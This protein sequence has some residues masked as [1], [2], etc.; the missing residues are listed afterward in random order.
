MHITGA[1][2]CRCRH[3]YID[4][5]N[6]EL[7]TETVKKLFL[8]YKQLLKHPAHRNRLCT[9]YVYITGGEPF[10]HKDFG[11][12][13]SVMEEFSPYFQFVMLSNG[14][15][16]EDNLLQR[17]RRLPLAGFQVSIDGERTTHDSIRGAGNFDQVIAGIQTLHGHGI[18]VTVSFTANSLNYRQ[19]PQVADICRTYHAATLWSDRYV[20]FFKNKVISSLDQNETREYIAM[21]EQEKQNP[22]NRIANMQILNHRSLQF[23]ASG[24][25]PYRCTAGD[26][27]FAIDEHGSMYPCRRYANVCGNIYQQ[28]ISDIYFNSPVFRELRERRIPTQ[29]N[30]CKHA[31]Y[32]RGGAKCQSLAAYG[33]ICQ[34]DPGCWLEAGEPD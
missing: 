9:P 23:L 15:M 4:A 30:L 33:D 20:P 25:I 29:C 14:T 10:C 5:H 8:Q 32:C 6:A 28:S 16:L 19:F 17:L 18:P 3:C 1:C 31:R 21:L 11:G 24:E 26:C 22:A 27:S 13:V 12:I 2:N 34:K 7:S